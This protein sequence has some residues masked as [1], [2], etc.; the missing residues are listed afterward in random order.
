MSQVCDGVVGHIFFPVLLDDLLLTKRNICM[1]LTQFIAFKANIWHVVAVLN[2]HAWL[3]SVAAS[4]HRD[5][6]TRN[7]GS[8]WFMKCAHINY[9]F[10][11]TLSYKLFI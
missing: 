6:Q 4:S 3:P 9:Q 5:D 10:D 8:Q 7:D 1:V 11:L 2:R